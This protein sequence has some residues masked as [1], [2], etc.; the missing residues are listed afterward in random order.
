V[1]PAER[2]IFV[3]LAREVEG[4]L[5]RAG[6]PRAAAHLMGRVATLEGEQLAK[7]STDG[8]IL[9]AIAQTVGAVQFDPVEQAML[10][11]RYKTSTKPWPCPTCGA[12]PDQPCRLGLPG[13]IH[14]ARAVPPL[15]GGNTQGPMPDLEIVTESSA[16]ASALS[17]VDP[18][19]QVCYAGPHQWCPCCNGMG[20]R[21]PEAR[22]TYRATSLPTASA[23]TVEP[24]PPSSAAAP[25]PRGAGGGSLYRDLA[26]PSRRGSNW[27]DPGTCEACFLR[28]PLRRE[29]CTGCG[30][31]IRDHYGGTEYRCHARATAPQPF[32]L[33]LDVGRL[34]LGQRVATKR[35]FGTRIGIVRHLDT[36]AVD[37]GDGYLVAV[38]PQDLEG[39]E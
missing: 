37:F 24:S 17:D 39:V 33:P 35:E 19:P 12:D 32:P 1:T 9:P 18:A 25:V 31:H 36:V 13:G 14:D 30:N 8:D 28:D 3:A 38:L 16:I 11:E 34:E 4:I 7:G 2:A 5:I 20:D 21:Q 6:Q 10:V 15:R 23:R 22:G 29:W 26:D 27:K